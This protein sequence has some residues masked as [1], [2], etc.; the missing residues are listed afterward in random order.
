MKFVNAIDEEYKP[1]SFLTYNDISLVP[2]YCPMTSRLDSRIDLN[3]TLT[4][5]LKLGIP[6]ISANM[7]CVTGPE[8]AIKM[9]QLGGLGILHRF[10]RSNDDRYKAVNEIAEY[11]D[12][13]VTLG[14]SSEEL[15][16][17][18]KLMS[19]GVNDICIDIAH[20][21]AI[22]MQ[23]FLHSLR[24]ICG[25]NVNFIVGNVS[26]T[27]GAKWLH[28]V[29]G[30]N[31]IKVGQGPGCFVA[32]TLVKTTNGY[33]NIEDL[34]NGDMVFTHKGVYKPVVGSLLR[35]AE[36]I[37]TIN[38]EIHCTPNHEFYVLHKKYV[39]MPESDIHL[40]AEWVP[41]E[42]LSDEYFMVS[43]SES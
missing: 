6:I 7:D 41:A 31:C 10:F 27:D 43:H 14:I 23:A 15:I 29:C 17:A 3:T 13:V 24:N 37:I 9:A 21:H 22:K 25:N 5:S 4:P 2:Q 16:F 32:G 18:E 20:A 39:D 38:E 28:E 26:T 36:E 12:P 35:T 11:A 19:V 1:T 30:V 34:Q 33:C 42:R 40:Y 8:M